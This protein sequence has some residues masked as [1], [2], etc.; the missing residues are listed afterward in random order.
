MSDRYKSPLPKLSLSRQ[1][2]GGNPIKSSRLNPSAMNLTPA[3]TVG[4]NGAGISLLGVSK[5]SASD[6][7]A[8]A[9]RA[10]SLSA[11]SMS[12]PNIQTGLTNDRR[13][14]ADVD[15]GMRQLTSQNQSKTPN[16][17]LGLQPSDSVN[18]VP[19]RSNNALRPKSMEH[20]SEETASNQQITCV[21]STPVAQICEPKSDTLSVT[22]AQE[23]VTPSKEEQNTLAQSL[24]QTGVYTAPARLQAGNMEQDNEEVVPMP[25]P[26]RRLTKKFSI[27]RLD[28]DEFIGF[29][30]LPEQVHRKAVKKGFEFTMIVMGET[31]LGK[32]TL[33]NS[34]FLTDLYK[35]RI[36]GS[37]NDCL[38]RTVSIEKKELE[39]EERGIKLKLTVV[40]TPGFNDAINAEESWLPVVHYIDRQFE[41]YYKAESGVNRKNIID[42]RVHCCLYFISP[43]GHG[44][45]PT[46]I[47][48][49]KLLHN[50]V[51]IVPLIAKSD[52]LTK[53]EVKRLKE[54]IM[55]EIK[56]NQIS[57]YQFPDCDSDEDEDFKEQ[58]RALKEA[59][60]FAVV[61][62]NTVVEAGGK[63]IRG[64]MYPWGIVEVENPNHCDF[65]KLRQMLI[66]THMQDLKDITADVHYENY[67]AQHI[68]SEM[69]YA[70]KERGKLKRDSKMGNDDTEKL[71]QQKEAEIKKMQEML[72]RMQA[73]LQGVSPAKHMNGRVEAM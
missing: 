20:K 57:I 35:D 28:D 47:A 4:L 42:T 1:T 54:R 26:R 48:V 66:S 23:M 32:S 30:T 68:A 73:Q 33:I 10:S 69:S 38:S 62:S 5:F 70:H 43:Y 37:V 36:V 13:V 16:T 41:Q 12:T 58:D 46:D 24:T 63:K 27:K 52:V 34:L 51:N 49:M 67:R 53:A 17:L 39:I 19:V 44:L 72:A 71:L 15:R 6:A 9:S 59:V 14:H 18:N 3:R 61:G 11:N 60:P 21:E 22:L 45:R 7:N 2:S 8:N 55:K 25:R 29:A 64:R 65:L 56:E 40:D 50:K 31:G